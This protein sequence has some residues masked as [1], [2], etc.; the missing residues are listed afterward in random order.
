MNSLVSNLSKSLIKIQTGRETN[1]KRNLLLF[2]NK[3]QH[4]SIH[5]LNVAVDLKFINTKI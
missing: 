5:E 2:V 1:F 4:H 3:Q